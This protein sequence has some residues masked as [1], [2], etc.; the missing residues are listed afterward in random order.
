MK[1]FGLVLCALVALASPAGA[2]D[3]PSSTTLPAPAASLSKPYVVT[4]GDMIA[5]SITQTIPVL[6]A[7]DPWGITADVVASY[8]RE[9]DKILVSIL[10]TRTSV[11]DAK[12][13]I[14]YFRGKVFPALATRIT[15]SYH[16]SLGEAD[17]TLVY[18]TRF[19]MHE[20]IRREGAKY[21]VAE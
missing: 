16:V 3:T 14:E 17:L 10:G 20:V 5:L 8:D 12:A 18:V 1:Q 7:N 2:L 11:D 19:N 9:T 21:L 6:K 13:A 15:K 4:L